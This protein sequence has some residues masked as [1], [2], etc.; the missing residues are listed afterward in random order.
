MGYALFAFTPEA[1]LQFPQCAKTLKYDRG[2]RW[3]RAPRR[4]DESISSV[5]S[6]SSVI[7]VAFWPVTHHHFYSLWQH[8]AFS[9][10]TVCMSTDS[11]RDEALKCNNTGEKKE[12]HKKEESFVHSVF[13]FLTY[14][15]SLAPLQ[16]LI[17]PSCGF[18]CWENRGVCNMPLRAA[19]GVEKVNPLLNHT[20]VKGIEET[21]HHTV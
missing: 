1:F 6:I 4:R 5:Y 2:W 13:V 10:F 20:G 15:H 21:S 12:H 18:S 8:W 19:A 3:S 14:H 9:C 7:T 17:S 16:L 11:T